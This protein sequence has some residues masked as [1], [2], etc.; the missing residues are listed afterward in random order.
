M[1][2]SSQV[3]RSFVLLLTLGSPHKF[4]ADSYFVANNDR[5]ESK[6][7]LSKH[8]TIERPKS[9]PQP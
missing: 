6:P 5:S 1:L 7:R 9:K 8:C 2:V 3:G 4:D